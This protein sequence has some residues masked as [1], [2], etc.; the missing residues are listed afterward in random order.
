MVGP[1]AKTAKCYNGLVEL[2]TCVGCGLHDSRL[3]AE[4]S[5]HGNTDKA[6]MKSD[7]STAAPVSPSGEA[8]LLAGGNIKGG[9]FKAHL[10][11]VFEKA[12]EDPQLLQSFW[13]RVPS[14][15][16]DSLSQIVLPF[17]ALGVLHDLA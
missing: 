2:S 5:S 13:D 7:I 15:V 12:G 17:R 1:Q 10:R 6:S 3:A 11:W 8:E 4:F 14:E 16:R 9:V